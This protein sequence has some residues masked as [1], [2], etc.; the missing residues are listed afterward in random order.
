MGLLSDDFPI[1][2]ED[3][4][5]AFSR[6]DNLRDYLAG[7]GRSTEHVA[8]PRG[9]IPDSTSDLRLSDFRTSAVGNLLDTGQMNASISYQEF[10]LSPVTQVE[11][12]VQCAFLP[13]GTIS[14]SF[15]PPSNPGG[16]TVW[17][18]FPSAPPAQVW[19]LQAAGFPE[20]P[21]A[22]ASNFAI[23]LVEQGGQP[24][25]PNAGSSETN[26]RLD[27]A[28]TFVATATATLSIVGTVTTTQT[29]TVDVTLRRWNGPPV[30][31]TRTIVLSAQATATSEQTP[32]I[33]GGGF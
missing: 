27:T 30:F 1:T 29:L 19:T 3:V 12:S 31:P 18:A 28:R 21:T 7:A 2:L 10:G 24:L 11:C 23:D 20:I 32:V 22:I 4:K 8:G 9:F 33:P 16:N 6:G 17:S 26:Q 15:S 5:G 13:N 25:R 14:Y